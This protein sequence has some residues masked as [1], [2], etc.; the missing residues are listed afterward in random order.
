MRSSIVPP[1][2]WQISFIFPTFFNQLFNSRKYLTLKDVLQGELGIVLGSLRAAGHIAVNQISISLFSHQ[3]SV[4]LPAHLIVCPDGS[5]GHLDTLSPVAPNFQTVTSTFES[6]FKS[7][8]GHSHHHH[9]WNVI[10][11]F[12][13]G[14]RRLNNAQFDAL[15]MVFPRNVSSKPLLVEVYIKDRLARWEAVKLLHH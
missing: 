9:L 11:V 13:F 5:P 6:I 2:D 12:G 3:R 4:I 14:R 8:G 15:L 10:F 1:E 7:I